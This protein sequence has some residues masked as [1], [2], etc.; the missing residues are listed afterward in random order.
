VPGTVRAHTGASL[1]QVEAM[2]RDAIALTYDVGPGS[3]DVVG[4]CVRRRGAEAVTPSTRHARLPARLSARFAVMADKIVYLTR[5]LKLSY[6]DNARSSACPTSASINCEGGQGTTGGQAHDVRA[7]PEPL[8]LS[9]LGRLAVGPVVHLSYGGRFKPD[10]RSRSA[11]KWGPDH[12]M[13]VDHP[14]QHPEALADRPAPSD[15]LAPT[16]TSARTPWSGSAD[17]PTSPVISSLQIEQ[18]GSMSPPQGRTQ[19]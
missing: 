9:E 14:R 19:R 3:F 2:A 18:G 17:S 15:P 6:R 11:R 1:D 13:D 8:S 5:E 10:R 7:K 16:P 4:P 12:P